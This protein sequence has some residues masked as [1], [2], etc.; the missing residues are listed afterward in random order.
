MKDFTF[1]HSALYNS[2]TALILKAVGD[3]LAQFQKQL[4]Y[5]K[6][7]YKLTGA[8]TAILLKLYDEK[9]AQFQIPKGRPSGKP[10]FK[11]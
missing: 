11:K 4:D 5:F 8:E 9:M 1:W 2:K 10:K 3:D 7:G 6:E